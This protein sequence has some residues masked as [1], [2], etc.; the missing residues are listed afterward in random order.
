VVSQTKMAIKSIPPHSVSVVQSDSTSCGETKEKSEQPRARL[1]SL[2]ELQKA[3]NGGIPTLLLKPQK[4]KMISI[5][6]LSLQQVRLPQ[7]G[8]LFCIGCIFWLIQK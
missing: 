3:M 8:F 2:I 4:L 1:V 6:I 7:L 5:S